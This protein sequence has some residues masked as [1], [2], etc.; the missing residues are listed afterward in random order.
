M[1]DHR[2]IGV[3]LADATIIRY[4]W[5]IA[6][7]KGIVAACFGLITIF[8]SFFL[9]IKNL[10]I[11]KGLLFE[12]S[13]PVG[14]AQVVGQSA[15]LGMELSVKCNGYDSLSL[16][17]INILPIPALDGGRALFVIIESITRKRV[18]MKYEQFAHTLGFVALMIL[19]IVVTWRDIVRIF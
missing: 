8:S 16:A 13:G 6:I 14:I 12:V 5:Y 9:L 15:K 18:P 7:W 19:I 3:I 4:P 2:R 1:E 17:A 10:I 11:G